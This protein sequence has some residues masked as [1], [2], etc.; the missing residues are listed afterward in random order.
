MMV[1]PLFFLQSAIA[2]SKAGLE[3]L[4]ESPLAPNFVTII[5]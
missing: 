1:P 3:L 4:I 2:L 5:L